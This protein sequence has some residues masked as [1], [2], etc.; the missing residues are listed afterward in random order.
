MHDFFLEQLRRPMFVVIYHACLVAE[1]TNTGVTVNGERPAVVPWRPDVGASHLAAAL[2]QSVARHRG[3]A[4]VQR[5]RPPS[6]HVVSCKPPSSVPTPEPPATE[7]D[8]R[9]NT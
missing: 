1:L 4:S 7:G 2:S 5:H 9:G 8:S 3:P 6:V